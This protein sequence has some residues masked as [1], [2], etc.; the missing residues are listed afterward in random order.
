MGTTFINL[1][2]FSQCFPVINMQYYWALLSY[3]M[4]IQN[5]PLYVMLTTSNTLT[6]TRI[7]TFAVNYQYL[8]GMNDNYVLGCRDIILFVCSNC[9]PLI[10][11]NNEVSAVTAYKSLPST[12]TT[13]LGCDV[14]ITL[15]PDKL[16]HYVCVALLDGKVSSCET[17]L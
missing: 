16:G 8:F 15:C 7:F 12:T 14:D 5:L 17:I 10:S 4:G 13:Y 6:V 2:T 1:N 3:R 11:H 9:C